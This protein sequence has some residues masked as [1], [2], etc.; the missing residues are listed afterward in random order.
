[1][2]DIN[3]TATVTLEANGRQAQ[4]T[5]ERLRKRA[6]DYRD[7][8][9][10]AAKT[11]DTK[12]LKRWHKELR[13]VE[14]QIKQVQN[15][16]QNV[17]L[18]MKK[19][20]RATPKEL[21]NTLKILERQLKNIERGS[22]AW[23]TQT[24]R[25]RTL[26]AELGRVNSEL[27]VSESR[28]N[29]INEWLNRAQF[30]VMGV[31]G[32][33]TGLIVA[34]KKA[35]QA[36]ADM[37]GEMANVRKFT[38]FTQEQVAELNE[39]FKN[40]DTRTSREALNQLAQE[41]G[42]LGKTSM[43]DVL[44]FVR[45][46]DKINVALDD[47]GEGATLTLSKLTQIFGD[48]QRLGTEQA[49]LSVGSVINELSQ[50]S[51]AAAPYL[52]EF[53]KRLGGVGSQAGMTVQQILGIAAVLDSKGQALEASA[54]AI[55]QVITRM[56]QDPAKYAKAAG[57]NVQKF[58]ELVRTDANEALMQLSEALNAKGGLKDT[59]P[60]FKEMGE[61]GS[62]AVAALST[63]AENIKEVRSQQEVAN[64]AFADGT[65]VVK[66]Y[67]VQ[68]NTVQA[69]LDK[70]KR[71]FNEI[72]VSLG[73]R[74]LPVMKYAI[75][76]TS[77]IMRAMLEI[78]NFVSENKGELLA[79]AAGIVTYTVAYT[80][81]VNLAIIKTKALAAAQAIAKGAT[82]AWTV[83]TE[84]ATGNFTRLK[85]AILALNASIK[86]NIWAAL[87]AAIAA[88]VVYVITFKNKVK[89]VVT[90]NKELAEIQEQAKAKTEDRIRRIRSLIAIQNDE[91]RSLEERRKAVQILNRL[92]PGYNAQL[93][94]TTKR[95]RGNKEALDKYIKSLQKKYE[96]EGA[97]EMLKKLGAEIAEQV[98][99]Q[100]DAETNAYQINKRVKDREKDLKNAIQNRNPSN[101]APPVAE[102][103]MYSIEKSR[104]DDE[105]A[106]SAAAGEKIKELDKKREAITNYYKPD[107]ENE[108]LSGNDDDNT[109]DG[110]GGGGGGGNTDK[111]S[112]QDKFAAED[113][114]KKQQEAYNRIHVAT[115]QI[116]KENG[117]KELYTQEDFEKRSYE[118]N[119]EYL[120]RK[121]K[122][123][124]ATAQ[125][126]LEF[127]AE[128][129]ELKK[130]ENDRLLAQERQRSEEEIKAAIEKEQ[131]MYSE[132]ISELKQYYL[133]GKISKE[134]MDE[135]LENLELD[136]LK[137][138]RDIH[139]KGTKEYLEADQRYQ[140]KLVQQ[141]EKRRKEIERKEQEYRDRLKKYKD[142][143]YE[144]TPA[145]R[146]A[147][148]QEKLQ[149]IE[150]V[151][152]EQLKAADNNYEELLALEEGFLKAKEKLDEEYGKKSGAAY[153]EGMKRVTEWLESKPG[154]ALTKGMD[155]A[156]SSMGAIFQ[157]LS[158]LVQ[159]EIEIQT[160]TINKR[161]DK[162]VAW[163]QGNSAKIAQ[164]E[165]RRNEE[166]RKAKNEAN[167]KMFSMQIIQAIA[168][169][170]QNAIAAFGSAVAVPI[171]GPAL[172][173]AAAAAAV[174][175]GMLQ[176]A[177][178][179]KQAKQA[180]AQGYRQ[181]GFT[182]RGRADQ[183]AGIV[184]AGEWVAS[185][186]LV[187]SPNTRPLIDAL[188]YAQRTNT[189]GSFRNV[190][191]AT[192]ATRT[193]SSGNTT[194]EEQALQATVA[195]TA[196]MATVIDKLNRRLDEPFVTINTV[197]G[198]HGIQ[199][200]ERK[201]EQLLKNK[202]R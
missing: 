74:L 55:S 153:M 64:Q 110:G 3:S 128:L 104:Y 163:A 86:L 90:A 45:A 134:S 133:D 49:L 30:A 155:V 160:A 15:E 19:L 4:E 193:I 10:N 99:I 98:A 120:E 166:L 200:A 162:E 174:A 84:L 63:L 9:A 67:D 5:L 141:A 33:I 148:Y 170:A 53:A 102:L 85:N 89:E 59:A 177:V 48:E 190:D 137:K 76:G 107:F 194:A 111:G 77:M 29:R 36:Y 151:Y 56:Y 156:I 198:D 8:L 96:L 58:T 11:G 51:A 41:A 171:I 54:T 197:T 78:I 115:G 71:G 136:H 2:A 93:D 146:E 108:A 73:E 169:T 95:Y 113:A 6:E 101:D 123:A 144:K 159:A 17:E 140:D 179:K 50:N 142:E 118:I 173:P 16:T 139:A 37:E 186:A 32:A 40:M 131:N 191:V 70:A 12:G 202:S 150:D 195:T 42:R 145:E 182:P 135:A 57:L 61:N 69:G 185:Q 188:E 129:A 25:I 39:E 125:E 87:A 72:A 13:A 116:I 147:E 66:E 23:K 27:R 114:W 122:N 26:R 201:Y 164:I 154:Q 124:K 7:A 81:A 14:R 92:I 52:A 126:K 181:G 20:D 187:N 192:V 97:K 158:S 91:K 18:V 62:R 183:P 79:L 172:A 38:G 199:Q 103:T 119:K 80:V 65:S 165:K 60:L 83:A 28:F 24:E 189:I 46:A 196:T 82:K 105:K 167:K 176:V 127:E 184:H 157:Q 132:S 35:V 22:D 31:I 43:D 44:G 175:A 88:L 75:S 94:E 100:V 168:Q 143:Y 109:T 1:M 68:N 34:G 152:K 138:M 112:T 21:S 106:K 180:E 117:K 130:K 178:I 149:G 121:L 161:Y 47:L